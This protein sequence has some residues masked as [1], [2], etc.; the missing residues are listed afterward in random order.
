MTRCF[1]ARSVIQMAL[2]VIKYV[3]VRHMGHDRMTWLSSVLVERHWRM[4]CR[5]KACSQSEI[6]GYIKCAYAYA[7]RKRC[8]EKKKKKKEEQPKEKKKENEK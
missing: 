2:G 6:R 4:H 5:Q 3:S 7:I 8:H 1:S